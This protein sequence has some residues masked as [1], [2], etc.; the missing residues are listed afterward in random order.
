MHAH[1]V[2]LLCT[3]LHM[4][5]KLRSARLPSRDSH[6]DA[7]D[8]VWGGAQG[9]A[10][11][12]L[13]GGRTAHSHPG[14]APMSTN[15]D[16]VDMQTSRLLV[17]G[18]QMLV[19]C[20]CTSAGRPQ[21]SRRAQRTKT[22]PVPMQGPVRCV[23]QV[24]ANSFGGAVTALAATLTAQRSGREPR[25]LLAAFLVG[26]HAVRHSPVYRFARA[27]RHLAHHVLF[28]NGT[29]AYHGALHT[30]GSGQICN[31]FVVPCVLDRRTTHAAALTRARQRWGSAAAR[32]RA[33][34][35]L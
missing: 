11:G 3:E 7:A 27:Q 16:P 32:R 1:H 30:A 25:W 31:G 23:V 10:G 24:L 18:L 13:Q 21:R 33:S 22:V 14:V 28:W 5:P 19:G 26:A 6:C 15:H 35:P 4:L 12:R 20:R 8:E 17:C 2:M 9:A 34:S 29:M